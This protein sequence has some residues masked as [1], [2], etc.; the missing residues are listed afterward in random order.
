[1]LKIKYPIFI[2]L[3][4]LIGCNNLSDE[5]VE[6]KSVGYQLTDFIAPSVIEQSTNSLFQFSVTF[7]NTESIESLDYNI[8]D[9]FDENI[10]NG[11][12]DQSQNSPS[13]FVGEYS[14]MNDTLKGDFILRIVVNDNFGGS[15][16]IL[17]HSFELIAKTPNSIPIITNLIAPDSVVVQSP[18]SLIKMSVE[19]SDSNGLA[20]ISEVYFKLTKPDGSTSGN[21]FAMFDDG[22]K[23]NHDDDIAGDGK[24][25]T[26]IEITPENDKG[27]YKFE[28]FAEDKSNTISNAI[29]HFI[30][31]L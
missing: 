15:S 2:L 22:N 23:T 31:I 8:K 7:E 3:F 5:I 30:E 10:E 26:I 20:D 14:F 29:T 13:T 28:F 12:L 19:V 21:K 11:K 27:K 1:M 9:E 4:Y 18:K 24:F 6:Q 25:S 16:E 17:Q